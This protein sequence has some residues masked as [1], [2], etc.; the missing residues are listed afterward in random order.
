MT[1]IS[2]EN[3]STAELNTTVDVSAEQGYYLQFGYSNIATAYNP[4]GV[5]YDNV[6]IEG[7]LA[8]EPTPA[9]SVDFCP[10][11]TPNEYDE[12]NLVWQDDFTGNILDTNVW[13]YMY[14]DGSQYG[15]PGWG[16]SEWQLYTDSSE[17]VYVKNG[18]LYIVPKYNA[19][20]DQY[21][22][23]ALS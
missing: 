22:R 10:N 5:L 4:S 6:V 3:W 2:K 8:P 7:G 9:P 21:R 19:S 14:G 12:F 23:T 13:S 11:I 17:N 18:C 16:N 15:I 20:E 1:D